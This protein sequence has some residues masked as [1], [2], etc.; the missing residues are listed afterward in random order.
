VCTADLSSFLYLC[1][2]Y[3]TKASKRYSLQA[4]LFNVEKRE[5]IPRI[6]TTTGGVASAPITQ[7][8]SAEHLAQGFRG[9][10][11]R[12]GP[13]QCIYLCTEAL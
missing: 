13:F 1:K 4:V 10:K 9:S 5:N 3:Y 6:S 11:G 7:Q 2:P 8:F 12:Y